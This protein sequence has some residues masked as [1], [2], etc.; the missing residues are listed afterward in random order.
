MIDTLRLGIL[1]YR[2][3]RLEKKVTV[4]LEKVALKLKNVAV[5]LKKVAMI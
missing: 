5:Q 1:M 3:M 2:Y 4:R